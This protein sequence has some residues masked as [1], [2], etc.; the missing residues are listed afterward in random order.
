MTVRRVVT[1][2]NDT[3]GAAFLSDEHLGEVQNLNAMLSSVWR[4]DSVSTLQIPPKNL[5]D[6]GFGFPVPGG[7]WVLSWSI[8]PNSV[9][10]ESQ[11]QVGATKAGDLPAGA[12][13]ATDSIDISVITSGTAIF[14]L[15]DGTERVLECGDLV[16]VNGVRHIWSNRGDET[17][18]V[19][20]FILGAE[21]T[22]H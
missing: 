1:G 15:D 11:D 20:S 19:L 16:V 10:G 5:A 17:A 18:T 14:A 2:F 12:A 9:A 3:G 22:A 4:T 8:P 6:N 13:H 21:R 7:A